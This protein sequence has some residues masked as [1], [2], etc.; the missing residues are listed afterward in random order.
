MYME[1]M[2]EKYN[3]EITVLSPLSI[4]AGAEK[5]LVKGVDFVEKDKKVYLLN[6][7]KMIRNG[8]DIQSLTTYFAD[9][10]AGAVLKMLEGK[11]NAVSDKQYDLPANSDNDIKSFIKNELS[12]KPIIP[13][14]SL[15]GAVRSVILHHLLAG[16]ALGSS[17]E[18]KNY[19][20]DSTKG[21]E[22]MRFIKF[23]D[24]EFNETALVNTKIFNLQGSGNNWQ[25]GWKHSGKETTNYY[26]ATGFNTLY[27][28]ILPGQQGICSIMF[29]KNA[30]D[31]IENHIKK[32]EKEKLFSINEFF[33]IINHHT[34]N[35]IR[36]E[37]N[38][39]EKYSTAEK[40]DE[41]IN[42]LKHISTQIPE[43][44]SACILK[45][46]AG[47]G[48]HSIT[49]DW[50]Y[51]DYTATGVWTGGRSNGKQKYK[52]RKIANYN[53]C[54][55]LM[56]FVKLQPISEQEIVKR[57]E[58]QVEK[59][60]QIA[61]EKQAEQER[62]GQKQKQLAD[63]YN[64]IK[65]ADALFNDNKL[66]EAKSCLEQA[67]ILVPDGK[68]HDEL[69]TKISKIIMEQKEIADKELA[70]LAYQKQ[71][72]ADRLAA[73]QVPLTEKLKTSSKIQ[74]MIGNIK[75]WMKLNNIESLSETDIEAIHTKIKEIFTSLKSRD[76]NNFSIKP[77]LEILNEELINQWSKE[78]ES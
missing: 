71:A 10:N 21:D 34:K 41:I 46:S 22:L 13:G 15:K 68:K 17:K 61:A 62:I 4:G 70:V 16:Q 24:A 9:K 67:Q 65:Q 73:N 3:I 5:D 54:F 11:L 64:L 55:S 33:Q 8:I 29:S 30:F 51:D 26:K 50:Q 14:S 32:S 31:K 2:N 52:S 63:Y 27:E 36:K 1:T 39:F 18:E 28:S 37:I 59:E 57:K 6:L 66:I 58:I 74:T 49:G 47:S 20:G 7:K 43:D 48:F 60:R 77:L 38:F 69:L 23:S 40:T 42:S 78:I 19:F 75:T 76:K 56:G 45:M 35:Y 12:S 53:D 72:E 25:G 44:G